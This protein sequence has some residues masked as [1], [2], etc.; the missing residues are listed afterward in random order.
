MGG[1]RLRKV[2]TSGLVLIIFVSLLLSA[3]GVAILVRGYLWNRGAR[4]AETTARAVTRLLEIRQD[5][6]DDLGPVPRRPRRGLG[7]NLQRFNRGHY[8]VILIQN[9]EVVSGGEDEERDWSGLPSLVKPGLQEVLYDGLEWQVLVEPV[10]SD[11]A[12]QVAVVTPWSQSL[13][14]IRALVLYQLV[15]SLV[16]FGFALIVGAVFSRR[17]AKPLEE[18]RDK[19]KE[20]GQHSV[21]SLQSSQVLEI[22]QLQHS[23]MEMSRRV[24]DSIA[25]QR[26]F[27]ADASHELKTPLTAI[28]GMLEL[29]QSHSDME[30]EDRVRALRV[31]KKE[32]DRMGSL[33]SDLLLLSR[34]QAQHS[35]EKE[36]LK[37]A[38]VANEQIQVL[39][40]LFPDQEF[41]VSGALE[42]ELEA[43][44]TAL[45]RILRNLLE[46]AA[47]Y[48]GGSPVKV[49]LTRSKDRLTVSVKDSGPG[50]PVDKQAHLFERFY[51][52]D[53]GRA[54]ADGG[55]GLGLAIVKALVEEAEGTISCLSEAGR[56]AEFRMEFPLLRR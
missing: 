7:R 26:R 16:V 6:L 14:L 27:V 18:L 21:V 42:S 50:I 29:L 46:N 45:A 34:A 36:R 1:I 51:R 38:D 31:A 3:A 17:L 56:G 48:A 24:T 12:D 28:T 9:G 11:L 25:S 15:I 54:R 52:T 49:E 13:R 55:H 5:R 37:V 30:P 33:I 35:G 23:F 53:A 39:R 2:L 32:A 40:L 43:N 8:H 4:E 41:L 10:T 20:V 47:R 44:P 19:T 22:T